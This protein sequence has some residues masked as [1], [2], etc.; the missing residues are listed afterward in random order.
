MDKKNKKMEF[1][2]NNKE[3][4]RIEGIQDSVVYVKESKKATY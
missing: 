1:K 3:E 4:Y 2:G